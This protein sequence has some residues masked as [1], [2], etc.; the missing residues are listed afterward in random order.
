MANN[1]VEI[2]ITGHDDSGRALDK[3]PDEAGKAGKKAG[4]KLADGF[5]SGSERIRDAKGRFVKAG[6]DA[7]EG[8]GEEAS[9]GAGRKLDG[10][11]D[12][13]SNA[14]RGL[15]ERAGKA[16][17]DAGSEVSSGLLGILGGGALAGG[18]AAAGAGVG[19]ALVGGIQ[20][21][22][23]GMDI[24]GRMKASL[25]MNP[26]DS[27]QAARVAGKAFSAAYAESMQEAADAV[28][29]VKGSL[30]DLKD[31]ASLGRVTR[32]ALNMAKVFGVDVAE[33]VSLA[34]NLISNGMAKNSVEA[35]DLMT[36]A[37]QK[38]PAALRGTVSEAAAEYGQFFRQVGLDGPEMFDA[39]VRGA[40]K[41][42]WGIDKTGDAIKE[43]TIR[44]G[45]ADANAKKALDGMGLN[46]TK[47]FRDVAT[48]GA[49]GAAAFDKIVKSILDIEDPS[50]RAQAALAIFGTPLED[51]GTS[52]IPDFLKSLTGLGSGMKGFRG[53]TNR[54]NESLDTGSRKLKAFKNA[55]MSALGAFTEDALDGINKFAKSDAFKDFSSGIKKN[56]L[57]ALKSFAG[58]VKEEI[59]P[60]VKDLAQNWLQQGSDAF[61]KMKEV[62][63]EYKPELKQVLGWFKRMA[64]FMMDTVIP[65]IGP[66]L[67]NGLGVS[68]RAISRLIAMVGAA[69]RIFNSLRS[70]SSRLRATAAAVFDKIGDA[71]S[72]LKRRL[73][74]AFSGA[75]NGLSNALR[76]ALNAVVGMWNRFRIPGVN[77][78]GIGKVGGWD[79]PD[80]GYFRTGGISR[81]GLSVINEGMSGRGEIV[82][83]PSGSMIYPSPPAGVEGGGV[84]VRISVDPGA[85]RGLV[86]EI[87]KAI[88]VEVVNAGRGSVRTLLQQDPRIA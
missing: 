26:A 23:E 38:V 61:T 59:I 63:A 34:Q 9:R 55:A 28:T 52:K 54:T 78:P 10:L 47:L 43:F 7:G 46:S 12:R 32:D 53:E 15:K 51:L 37:F 66:F 27:A 69:V 58:W 3:I 42:Q 72:A 84:D 6:Q 17:R 60:A 79:S 36:K 11:R 49:K 25:G 18:A 77:I 73:S 44:I 31:D 83:L 4:E 20:K 5:K 62:I 57:P 48:G 40:A 33:S 21:A 80:I 70:S 13:L 67:A 87:I 22:L 74:G 85:S 35:F 1:E 81:G 75:F 88:R 19:V 45:G 64:D 82:K 50:K 14:F 68:I 86:R 56:V 8:Y 2:V 16:G 76:S 39:L 29:I 30:K 24:R 65:T 71:A 41:G